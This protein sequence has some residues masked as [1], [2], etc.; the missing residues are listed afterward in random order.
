MHNKPSH[1]RSL[2][3]AAL[4]I[5]PFSFTQ[6]A[7]LDVTNLS[8]DTVNANI[9]ATDPDGLMTSTG[10]SLSLIPPADIMMGTF[11]PSIFSFTNDFTGGSFT[12]NVYSSG[13]TGLSAPS[14]T[15][16]DVAGNFSNADLSSLRLNG[17][18]TFDLPLADLSFDTALFTTGPTASFYDPMS[19]AFSLTWAIFDQPIMF[20]DGSSYLTSVD[21]TISGQSSV[22]PVP[23]ALWLFASGMLGLAGFLRRKK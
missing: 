8:V 7:L 16:N 11:Q 14:A 4:L 12:G 1:I 19:G 21:L 9:S 3:L 5:T 10:A 15:V 6:A 17:L 2:L 22:V 13:D 23:A 18:F 20:S